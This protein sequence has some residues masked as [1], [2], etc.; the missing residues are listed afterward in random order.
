MLGITEDS[1]NI[2]AVKNDTIGDV[3]DLFTLVLENFNKMK[4]KYLNNRIVKKINS[5]EI[6]IEDLY[7]EYFVN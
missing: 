7:T 2:M 5:G 6:L 4:I 1:V 3:N